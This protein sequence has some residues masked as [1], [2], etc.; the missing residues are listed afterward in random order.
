MRQYFLYHLRLSVLVL[1]PIERVNLVPLKVNIPLQ[2]LL[3][4]E[5]RFNGDDPDIS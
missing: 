1:K 2:A 4:L 3:A 5:L